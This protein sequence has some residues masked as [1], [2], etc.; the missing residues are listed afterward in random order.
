MLPILAGIET[1]Y[2]LWIEG[3]GAEQQADDSATL[4]RSY[5]GE[6][7]CIWDYRWENPRADLRGFNLEKLARDPA[8]A[9]FDAG[10]PRRSLREEHSDRILANGARFYNDHGH[11]EYSTPETW[12]LDELE[13]HDL[14]GEIAVARAATAYSQQTGHRVKLYKNNADFHGASYGT[15]ENYLVPRSIPIDE[16]IRAVTPML[17]AR[18]L[19]CGTGK[20]SAE[21]NGTVRFQLSQ[22][23]DF[24][25]EP[26]NTE[27]LF[28]RPIF[29]T[30]DEPHADRTIWLRLHVISGDANMISRCTRR[31]V[32]LVKIALALLFC[33]EPVNWNFRDPVKAIQ[34]ISQSE[35]GD[36][37]IELQGG[38]WTTATQI[39]ESYFSAARTYLDATDPTC[40]ELLDVVDDCE[41][42]I[43]QLNTAPDEF[44]KSVDWAAKKWLISAY[45]HEVPNASVDELMAVDLAY[46]DL[47][48]NDGMYFGLLDAGEVVRRPEIECIEKRLHHV[49]EDTRARARSV[50]VR[51]F[52]K[53]LESLSWGAMTFSSDSGEETI[54]LR[55][56]GIFGSE[57]EIV[58]DVEQFIA[59]LKG[60]S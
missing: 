23:A 13:L 11:P 15:H 53:Q 34:D 27:T 43:E 29:N 2:G 59:I 18:Q 60:K 51:R 40:R 54:A 5:P 31:K 37:R 20:V 10:R 3:R 39:L 58:S 14:A 41:C 56:D 45:L 24:F 44:R 12:S 17:V 55:P 28:R 46:H 16:L 38:S 49:F 30:R 8:D 25:A 7:F 19:L 36:A 6:S 48:R 47:D 50:A 21:R 1:E 26:V 9:A 32:G 52:S 57:L 33:G 4:V 35:C 42:L 22:R